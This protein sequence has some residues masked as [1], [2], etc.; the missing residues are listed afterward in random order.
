MS[1]SKTMAGKDLPA[2]LTGAGDTGL[3]LGLE[4]GLPVTGLSVGDELG[5]LEGLELGSLVGG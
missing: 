4:V 2:Q 3:S 1:E 5:A